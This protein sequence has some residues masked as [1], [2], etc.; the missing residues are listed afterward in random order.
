METGRFSAA[1]NGF[2]D[3]AEKTIGSLTFDTY[4]SSACR[5]LMNINLYAKICF[6][7]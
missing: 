5:K 4:A 6:V 7:S 2:V 3:D 1:R